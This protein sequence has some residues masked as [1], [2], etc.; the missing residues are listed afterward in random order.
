MHYEVKLRKWAPG[1]FPR[2]I[3]IFPPIWTPGTPGRYEYRTE[4]VNAKDESEARDLACRKVGFDW[5]VDN[6]YKA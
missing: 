1:E 6:I 2:P 3:L 5:E 4:Y